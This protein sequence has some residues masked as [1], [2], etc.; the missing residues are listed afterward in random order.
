MAD[1]FPWS[2]R[3]LIMDPDERPSKSHP[4]VDCILWES[5]ADWGST[6][7][8]HREGQGGVAVE[9]VGLSVTSARCVPVPK[10][11]PGR[12]RA[13]SNLRIS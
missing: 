2:K 9:R 10:R 11:A 13:Q 6:A 4:L 3:A 8:P 12:R 1:Q 5:V 7:T